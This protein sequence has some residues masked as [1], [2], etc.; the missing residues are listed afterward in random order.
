MENK[1]NSGY[2]YKINKLILGNGK[3]I[4]PGRINVFVGANNCG[5]TQML[6]DMLEIITGSKEPRVLLDSID[7]TFPNVWS[8]IVDAYSMKIINTSGNYQ[9]RHVSPTLVGKVTGP[10]APDFKEAMQRWLKNEDKHLFQQS[11]GPGLVTYLNTDNRLQLAKKQ[12]VSKLYDEG[13]KNVLEALYLAGLPAVKKIEQIVKETFEIDIHF[14]SS[15]LG[16]LQYKVGID[17][18]TVPDKNIEAYPVV[19]TYPILDNQGDGLRGFLGIAS[20]LVSVQKPIVLLDEPE[21]FLHP[22]QAIKMGEIISELV[23]DSKQIFIATHN[24]DFLRGLLSTAKDAVIIHLNRLAN[25]K[26]EVKV[27]DQNTLNEIVTDPLLS[28]SRVL[29]GMFYKGVVATEAD[30]DAVFYQRLYQRIGS[31]DEI[32]FFNAHNKQTL[33]KIIKPYQKLGVR[34]AMIA[35]ADIIRDTRELKSIIG[36]IANDDLENTIL[37]E[38][39]E[40]YNF[41]QKKSKY[42]ILCELKREIIQLGTRELPIK[43]SPDKEITN[44]IDEIRAELKKIREGADELLELKKYGK[45]SL[46]VVEQSVFESFCCHCASVGLFVVKVGELESWLEDYGVARSSKKNKWISKALE[47]LYTI[48]VEDDKE[49]WKFIKEIQQYFVQ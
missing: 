13:A 42:D 34:F 16:T 28:S 44:I 1:I 21:A 39:D 3:E 14:D 2:T 7:A 19:S 4:I 37:S 22:P 27:L 5:K 47:K 33:K 36:E 9:I 6:K 8:E 49:I 32:H 12:G 29:E 30:A 38:R 23:D 45:N 35:D 40:V 25:D 17:S 26:T 46:P 24:A 15:D 43:D 20:A 18:S 31:K 11:V 41:F 10:A 48:E